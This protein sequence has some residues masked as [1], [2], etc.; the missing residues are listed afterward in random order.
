MPTTFG[1][2]SD[3][4]LKTP[5]RSALFFTQDR[6]SPVAQDRV[7]YFGSPLA[8]RSC[9]KVGGV[10]VSATGGAASDIKLAA[11]AAGLAGAVGGAPLSL[12]AVVLGGVANARAIHI[13]ALDSTHAPGVNAGLALALNDPTEYDNG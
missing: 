1:F 7:V 5:V 3:A 8:G 13:R 12:G 11:S 4:S 6:T 2:F 10:I 9:Q